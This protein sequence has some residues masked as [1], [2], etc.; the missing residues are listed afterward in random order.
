M[1][2]LY[3]AS[4]LQEPATFWT[5]DLYKKVG[6]VDPNYKFAF[7]MELFFRFVTSGARFRHINKFL[8]SFRIHP[9]SKSSNE[10]DLCS[11]EVQ[12]LREKY[13]PFPFDSLRARAV[14]SVARARRTLWYTQQGDLMWLLGRIPDRLRSRTS[15]VI[16]GP[17]PIHLI[18]AMK[19]KVFHVGWQRDMPE[20]YRSLD[21]VVLTSLWEGLPCVF[22]EAMAGELPIAA[23]NVDGAREA[24]VHEDNGF[25]H[26]PH[27]LEGMAESLLRLIENRQLRESMGKRGKS[28]VMEVEY[29]ESH[30]IYTAGRYGQWDYYSMEDSIRS[31]KTIAERIDAGVQTALHV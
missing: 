26:E 9:T 29:L 4:D 11:S 8:A 25:L 5:G 13:L 31:G 16:V 14:R 18:P 28:R 27:D 10:F 12:R 21:F 1:G 23:T 3:G 15:G 30:N 20:V 2:Y 17:S 6:G 24:I 19:P 22:S 7:D